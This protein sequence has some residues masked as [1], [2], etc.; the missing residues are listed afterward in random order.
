V[1]ASTG[2]PVRLVAECNDCDSKAPEEQDRNTGFESF[3]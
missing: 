2:P 3:F 1:L